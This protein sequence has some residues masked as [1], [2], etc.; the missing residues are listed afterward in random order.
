MRRVG[1]RVRRAH[2]SVIAIAI[3]VSVFA[4][5]TASASLWPSSGDVRA[6]V[7]FLGDSNETITA[8]LIS[9]ALLNR[10]DGYALVSIARPGATIRTADCP[11]DTAACPTYNFWQARVSDLNHKVRADAYVVD[12]G[13]NDTTTPGTATSPG[14]ADYGAKIDWLM[15]QIGSIPVYWSNLPCKIEP[16][17]RLPGCDAVNSA[18]A[19]APAR[20]RNL[21]VI[22]WASVANTHP[23][24][25]SQSFAMVH[26]NDAGAKAWSGLMSSALD[27][28]FPYR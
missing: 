13:I 15:R 9:N 3:S 26:L 21:V 25:V 4:A 19:A 22:D 10:P 11:S 20:H 24:Y 2:S 8:G 5:G 1:V 16:P 7:V 23:D 17:N 12:L 27:G 14:Y 6:V 28:R 18:L